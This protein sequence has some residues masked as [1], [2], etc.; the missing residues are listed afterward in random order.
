MNTGRTLTYGILMNAGGLQQWQLDCLAELE[1]RGEARAVVRIVKKERETPP[2]G[3][4]QKIQHYPY[5]N[6]LFRILKRFFF[7]TAAQELRTELPAFITAL[8]LIEAETLPV[9]KYGERFSGADLE[10]IRAHGPDFLIRFGF[11]ILKGDILTLCPLGI[12]SFHH[13]DEVDFRGGPPG[14]WEIM[15]H[16]RRTSVV[17]QRL[18]E[19][20]DA[21]EILLKRRYRTILH[22]YTH[23]LQHILNASTDMPAQWVSMY[24]HSSDQFSYTP[25]EVKPIHTFPQNGAM[26]FFIFRIFIERLRF[27]RSKYFGAEK[28]DIALVQTEEDGFGLKALQPLK[29][30]GKGVY[31]ADPFIYKDLIFYEHYDYRRKKGDIHVLRQENGHIKE[32]KV[33]L[34]NDTHF[35]FPFLFEWENTLYTAPE[36]AASGGWYAYPIDSENLTAGAPRLIHPEPLIDAVLFEHEDTWYIF[37]GLP[38]E[39]NEKLHLWYADHPFGPYTRHP[40]S[41][42]KTDPSGSRMAGA[43]FSKNG[44]WYRPAQKSDRYYGEQVLGFEITRL[45]RTDYEEKPAFSLQAPANVDF[46]DGLHT[47]NSHSGQ[48]VTDL[49]KHA[50]DIVSLAALIR[51]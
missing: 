48:S 40:G 26:L 2:Q 14:F 39:A 12:L 33:L 9:G 49:K 16:E 42:L 13:G 45:N 50:S 28:W 11:N 34:E 5:Q 43:I 20:L 4:I 3:F 38:G 23:Q 27:Y 36:N 47:F 15:R 24:L 37:A 25:S 22:S 18:G 44:K 30:Y 8:P 32:Q 51:R 1:K 19:K 46:H 7:R 31:A 21:G 6:F 29:L 10:K 41:P 17:L 35:A